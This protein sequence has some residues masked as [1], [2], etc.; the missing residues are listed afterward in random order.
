M[1]LH[2]DPLSQE[3]DSHIQD[4]EIENTDSTR[5]GPLPRPAVY[6]GDGP[7]DAPSSDDEDVDVVT[8]KDAPGPLNR[9]ENGSMFRSHF[10]D[11]GLYVGGQK[12]FIHGLLT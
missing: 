9:A 1:P 7:F 5:A 3:D 2:Y 8:E 10:A 12:V 4:T 6:Y 11:N